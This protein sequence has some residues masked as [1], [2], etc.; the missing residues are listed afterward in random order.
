MVQVALIL[1][2]ILK[3]IKYDKDRDYSNS[4]KNSIET[5]LDRYC[6]Q[7]N[8]PEIE[9]IFMNCDNKELKFK[10]GEYMLKH[11]LDKD[12]KEFMKR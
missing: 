2:V 12:Y 9:N 6:R 5:K 8:I 4:N 10:A 3:E 1:L 7:G 11:T